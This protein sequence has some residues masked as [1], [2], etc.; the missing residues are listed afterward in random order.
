M[1]KNFAKKTLMEAIE[2]ELNKKPIKKIFWKYASRGKNLVLFVK[3]L[4]VS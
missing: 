2:E 1:F 4:S 3:Y